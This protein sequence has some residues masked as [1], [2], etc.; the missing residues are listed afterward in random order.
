M[1]VIIQSRKFTLKLLSKQPKDIILYTC[2]W[3]CTARNLVTV[4][5]RSEH[6][7]QSTINDE[8]KQCGEQQ[9]AC[10]LMLTGCTHGGTKCNVK[11]WLENLMVRVHLRDL[12]LGERTLFN[13]ASGRYDLKIHIVLN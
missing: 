1:H 10:L 12:D 11:I 9:Q 4:I 8:V 3:L 6:T 7:E 5:Q 2:T 13:W